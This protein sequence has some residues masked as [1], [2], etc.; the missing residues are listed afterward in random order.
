MTYDLQRLVL[1]RARELVANPSTW[2]KCA[3]A[4][5]ARGMPC[6][7]HQS[8][9]VRFCAYGAMWRA[10]Y[11]LTGD[12]RAAYEL[13][14]GTERLVMRR[15]SAPRRARIATINDRFGRLAVLGVLAESARSP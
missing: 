11:E 5:D 1:S 13:A 9:A 4:R 12:T 7:P 15:T 14:I 3:V 2:T 10:A 6:L 8:R